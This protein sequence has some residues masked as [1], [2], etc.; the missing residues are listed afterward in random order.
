MIKIK[1]KQEYCDEVDQFAEIVNSRS[2]RPVQA[3]EPFNN[4]RK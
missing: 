2:P 4:I 1:L 3:T